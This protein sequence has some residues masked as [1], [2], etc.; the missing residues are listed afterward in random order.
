MRVKDGVITAAAG[1]ADSAIDVGQ[2][3]R[4]VVDVGNAEPAVQLQRTPA[5]RRTPSELQVSA[6]AV[7]EQPELPGRVALRPYA[8][9]VAAAHHGLEKHINPVIVASVLDM[10]VTSGTLERSVKNPL[11][12][13]KIG[14]EWVEHAV[15]RHAGHRR[16]DA[17]LL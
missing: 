17:L 15:V 1:R 7:E 2:D 5:S 9:H 12:A 13:L 14:R 16:G 3:G 10:Y 6:F 11:A 8:A 4:A